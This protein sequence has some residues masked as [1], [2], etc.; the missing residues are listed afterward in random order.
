MKH[1][2]VM[3]AVCGILMSAAAAD[4]AGAD[5]PRNYGDAMRWYEK[6]AEAGNTEAQFLLGVQYESGVRAEIRTGAAAPEMDRAVAW[7]AKAAGQGHLRAQLRLADIL[8]EGRG[9]ARDPAAA[10]RWY[11]AAADQGSGIAAYNLGIMVRRGDGVAKD[12]A[13]AAAW[14]AKAFALGVGRA[15]L[16]LAAQYALGDG[17]ERDSVEALAWLI[18]AEKAGIGVGEDV[19]ASVAADLTAE[20]RAEAGRRAAAPVPA[21]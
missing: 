4:G 15:A 16:E 2:A 5:V 7:Y 10:A 12:A 8:F 21:K 13:Q 19:R 18:R 3:L 17:V 11:R 6:A 1:A 14:A 9:V 20:Q